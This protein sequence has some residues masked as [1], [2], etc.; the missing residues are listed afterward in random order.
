M[1]ARV[2][3]PGAS[4][5]VVRLGSASDYAAF[6]ELFP[7]LGVDDRVPSLETWTSELAPTTF[8]AADS[9]RTVG[10]CYFQEFATVGYVRQI[11]VA[12]D[13]RRQGVGQA[14]LQQTAEHLKRAGLRWWELNVKPDNQAAIALYE[15]LGLREKYV[16]RSLRLP[17]VALTALPSG[18]ATVAV[19]AEDRDADLERAFELPRGQLALARKAGRVLLEACEGGATTGLAVFDPKFPGAFP[20]RVLAQAA[21]RPLLLAVRAHSL[22][23]DYVNLVVEGDPLTAATLEQAGGILRLETLHFEGPLRSS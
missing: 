13:A 10:F 11:A 22:G 2:S 5:L 4:D 1:S 16:S 21:L 14:L 7:E 15:T 12:K 17:W 20:F 9:G 8:V 18:V 3:K 23:E 19:F 6:A